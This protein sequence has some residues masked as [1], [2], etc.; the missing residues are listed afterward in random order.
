MS[1]KQEADILSQS[2]L[3]YDTDAYGQPLHLN[4]DS[5]FSA[6]KSIYLGKGTP[7]HSENMLERIARVGSMSV[8]G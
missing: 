2:L 6:L 8:S 1:T 5:V 7:K 3:Y 4:K